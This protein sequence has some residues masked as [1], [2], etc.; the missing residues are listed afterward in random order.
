MPC[1]ANVLLLFDLTCAITLIPGGA[2][3]VALKSNCPH[4][5]AYAESFGLSLAGHSRLSVIL[6]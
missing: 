4:M 5:Y 3:G 6:D 1:S 2:S